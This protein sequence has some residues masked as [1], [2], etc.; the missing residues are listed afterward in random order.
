MNTPR[1]RKH[2]F[3]VSPVILLVVTLISSCAKPELTEPDAVLPAHYQLKDIRYFLATSDRV[4]TITLP[5]KATSV[6]NPSSTSATQQVTEDLSELIR[7]SQFT[8]DPAT[9]LPKALDLSQ[10]EVHVPQERYGNGSNSLVQSIDTYPFSSSRQQKPYAPNGG[11]TSTLVIPARSK[12]DIVR[13]I[14][15]Y[16]LTCSFEGLLENTTTGQRYLLTGKWAG[17]FQYNN[18]GVTLKQSAL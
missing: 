14:D 12:I 2:S 3:L 13:Q 7:T 10:F 17:I 9:Q 16:Q 5:L 1:I 15:A 18:L 8:L 4:D 6:Q 11:A